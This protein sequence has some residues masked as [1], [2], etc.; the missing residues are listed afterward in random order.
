MTNYLKTPDDLLELSLYQQADELTLTYE[1]STGAY[2]IRFFEHGCKTG[3]RLIAPADLTKM[4]I[5]IKGVYLLSEDTVDYG[6]YG[7]AKPYVRQ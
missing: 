6:L 2:R 1:N 7:P 3:S 4:L 5:V